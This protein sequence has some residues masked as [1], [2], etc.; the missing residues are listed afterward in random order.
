MVLSTQQRLG[1]FLMQGGENVNNFNIIYKILKALEQVID[2]DE[3]DMDFVSAEHLK[4]TENRLL[5]I[6]EML[7]K[8]GYVEGV[9]VKYG[10]QGNVV[11]SVNNP[12]ITLKGL[13]YL[14]ENSFMKKAANTLK[15][16]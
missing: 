9:S 14:N 15:E 7:Y 12:R 5:R 2:Y 1:A 6:W 11:I 16:L 4:I 13:E 3:F 8:A 10:A